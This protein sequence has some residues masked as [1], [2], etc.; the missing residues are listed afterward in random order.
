MWR[1]FFLGGLALLSIVLVSLGIWDQ[2][3]LGIAGAVFVAVLLLI[4]GIVRVSVFFRGR[5]ENS[6]A[7]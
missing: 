5:K 4:E 6:H 1:I 3:D 7:S 2:A